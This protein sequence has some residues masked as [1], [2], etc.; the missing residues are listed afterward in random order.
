MWDRLLLAIDQFGTGQTALDFT[1]GLASA[2]GSEVRV[3]HLRELPRSLRVPPLETAAEARSLVEMA[4][5]SLHVAG[6]VAE[7]RAPSVR[8][9]R[10]AGAIVDEAVRFGADVIVLGSRRLRGLGRLS[11]QGVREA[12]LRLSPLP[13]VA[14]PA[15]IAGAIHPPVGPR[16]AL[17]HRSADGGRPG[18]RRA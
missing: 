16:A 18:G 11:S 10:V 12:V 14:A 17:T 4:V 5:R 6:V 3:L 7:G 15:P 9:E 8:S 1:A 13:V 2:T